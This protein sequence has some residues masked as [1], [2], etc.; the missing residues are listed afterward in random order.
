MNK[1]DL[2]VSVC[3]VPFQNPV[4]AASGCFGFGQEMAEYVDLN[5]LGGISIKGLTPKPRLGNPAPRIAETPSGMLNSVGLQ[6]PGIDAFLEVEL[7]R[8]AKLNCRIL[9][10]VAGSSVE[11][12]AYMTEKLANQPVDMVELNISCPNVKEGG[13]AFGVYPDKVYEV[14]SAAKAHCTQPLVVKLTPNTAD[15]TAT[16]LAAEKAGADAI[17]LINTL[18]GM[19]VDFRARRPI[20]ANVTGG[21][22]GPAVKPV[23]LRMVYQVAQAVNVPVIGMGGIDSG[24]DALEFMLCGASAVQVGMANLYDPYA[25]VRIAEEMEQILAEE[26][27]SSVQEI[28]G[29]LRV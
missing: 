28:I 21:L 15:I 17:S 18:T 29:Q 2:S 7:P 5:A 1:P 12:Y 13:V 19:A 9:A 26:G 20:L 22:S 23:A 6:N 10:N 4:I 11:D 14:V 16:A 24:L 27:L 25:C 3:G 8:L